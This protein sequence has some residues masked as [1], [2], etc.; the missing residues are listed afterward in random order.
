MKICVEETVGTPV[1][2]QVNATTVYLQWSPA[3]VSVRGAEEGVLDSNISLFYLLQMQHL[4]CSTVELHSMN[5]EDRLKFVSDESWCMQ[6]WGPANH[7]QVKGLRPGMFY[8]LRVECHCSTENVEA[9]VEPHAPSETII[10]Q[11]EFTAPAAMLPPVLLVKGRNSLKLHLAKPEEDGGDPITEYIVEGTPPP[12]SEFD[13]LSNAQGL[14]EVYRGLERTFIWEGLTPGLR[15]YARAKAVNSHGEGT[16]SS[17]ASFMTQATVPDAPREILVTSLPDDSAKLEWNVPKANGADILAYTVELDDGSGQFSCIAKVQLPSL[18]LSKLAPKTEY[19]IRVCAENSEGCGEWSHVARHLIAG[20]DANTC[21]TQKPGTPKHL[22]HERLKNSSIFRWD[23]Q[24]AHIVRQKYILEIS[25]VDKNKNAAHIWKVRYKSEEPQHEIHTLKSDLKYQISVKSIADGGDSS[26]CRPI[27]INMKDITG[28]VQTPC[29]PRNFSYEEGRQGPALSWHLDPD[30]AV[31]CIFELY[32]AMTEDLGHKKNYVRKNAFNL[33]YRGDTMSHIL[34]D[35]VVANKSYTARVRAMRSGKTSQ[36]SEDLRFKKMD[37]SRL[38]KVLNL[39]LKQASSTSLDIVW[40]EVSHELSSRECISY[41][42]CVQAV[43]IKS[44]HYMPGKATE[45]RN[46]GVARECVQGAHASIDDLEPE[47]E[48]R[49]RV[50]AQRGTAHGQWSDTITIATLASH[51]NPPEIFVKSKSSEA[52]ELAWKLP[53]GRTDLG[54]VKS[55]ELQ[56]TKLG[57]IERSP[58]QNIF[59]DPC[60]SFNVSGLSV[61]SHYGFRIRLGYKDGMG[62]WGSLIH[63]ETDPGP[64]STPDAPSIVSTGVSNSFK[65]SWTH[66]HDNG[67]RITDFELAIAHDAMEGDDQGGVMSTTDPPRQRVIYHGPDLTYR[68]HNLGFGSRYWVRVRASNHCGHGPW[69]SA[70][71]IETQAKPPGP[72]PAISARIDSNKIIISWEAAHETSCECSGYDIEVKRHNNDK[73][74]SE[75]KSSMTLIARKSCNASMRVCSIPQP[76]IPGEI[77]IRIRSIGA[78]GSGHG[79]WSPPYFFVNEVIGVEEPKTLS[80]TTSPTSKV[81]GSMISKRNSSSEQEENMSP[82]SPN[83]AAKKH[84]RKPFQRSATAKPP[85]LR[86]TFS[87][88]LSGRSHIA[89]LDVF[90]FMFLCSLFLL[91]YQNACFDL[92]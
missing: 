23:P 48:Y 13:Y 20:N 30:E 8:A 9:E 32:V 18:M 5:D 68:F 71:L 58:S 70:T 73:H 31:D 75:R 77:S 17:M 25:E 53:S 84:K 15:Y 45:S 22:R 64:P 66:P 72:P 2:V 40:E 26:Y 36:W 42:I 59:L 82:V 46:L 50:R 4:A 38:P 7:V 67:C 85:K 37:T 83:S 28:K 16:F 27:F 86:F 80:R 6:Y 33:L 19:R 3:A 76:D 54:L 81:L 60:S 35:D 87:R 47:T 74:R 52:V 61:G 29:T 57:E 69:S 12:E 24:G 92:T 39:R 88:L 49:V 14:C 78:H 65:I 51:L 43:E 63:V 41:A 90:V 79:P 34:G 1:V 55:V 62:V 11:T 21:S 89:R 44:A 91:L 10:F 56:Q